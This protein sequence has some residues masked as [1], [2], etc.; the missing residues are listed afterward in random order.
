M[1]LFNHIFAF[2]CQKIFFVKNIPLCLKQ[3]TFFSELFFTVG[4]NNLSRC[5]SKKKKKEGEFFIVEK[6]REIESDFLDEKKY[7]GA[8][9]LKSG[10]F[11]LQ[12]F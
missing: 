10:F 4:N 8:N 9:W 6:N 11:K 3:M 7:I 2:F 5:F 12:I 1:S